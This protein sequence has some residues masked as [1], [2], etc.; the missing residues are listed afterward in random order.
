M[1]TAD[2]REISPSTE[3]VYAAFNGFIFSRDTR[4]IAK[5]LMRAWLFERVRNIPGDIVECGV[6]KGSGMAS[7]LKIRAAMAPNAFK[8]VV[9]FDMFDTNALIASL[10]AHD[11]TTMAELFAGRSFALTP[12][13]AEQLSDQLTAMGLTGF[14]LVVG[15][16]IETSQQ[17][18]GVRPGAKISI[19]YIDLD[20]AE[21]TYHTLVNLWPLVSDG[22]YVVFDEYG[23]HTWSETQGV[24]RFVR[25]RGLKVLP[26]DCN[27]PTA[28][29]I[30]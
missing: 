29:L 20:L 9:G 12:S 27:S 15:N 22:G 28:Y 24:D 19:L 8:R 1:T 7:W 2:K 3:D 18:V 14:E 21:P 4:V 16:I 11:K 10:D 6:F 5:L 30:K 23:Y 17:Y 25:E 26:L 13:Y